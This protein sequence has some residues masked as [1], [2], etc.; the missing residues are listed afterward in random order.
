MMMIIFFFFHFPFSLLFFI[1]F[2]LPAMPRMMRSDYFLPGMECLLPCHYLL[3]C[4]YMYTGSLESM[5]QQLHGKVAFGKAF[6]RATQ[7][8][9]LR[10]CHTLQAFSFLLPSFLTF[11]SLPLSLFRK[12]QLPCHRH[13]AGSTGMW[14]EAMKCCHAMLAGGTHVICWHMPAT[15]TRHKDIHETAFLPPPPPFSFPFPHSSTQRHILPLPPSIRSIFSHRHFPRIIFIIYSKEVMHYLYS[16]SYREEGRI[17]FIYYI[18][19]YL[20]FSLLFFFINIFILRRF[21]FLFSSDIYIY[22]LFHIFDYFS[23]FF[24]SSLLF[25]S[26]T[27][28][29]FSELPCHMRYFSIFIIFFSFFFS[30]FI[31]I[32][33]EIFSSCLWEASSFCTAACLGPALP[34][35]SSLPPH[36]DRGIA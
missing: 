2:S 4:I 30:R 29:D 7:F 10:P 12:L 22:R 31:F 14:Q 13:G 19:L 17:L 8:E 24:L 16:Y 23:F 26:L 15:H 36:R 5:L 33:R 25:I 28:H 20:Y 9:P 35:S 32:Y 11:L 27:L 6:E 18:L 3:T 21:H 34:S 1:T